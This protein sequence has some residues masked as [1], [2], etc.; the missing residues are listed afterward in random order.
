MAAETAIQ[1]GRIFRITFGE[2]LRT[3]RPSSSFVKNSVLLKCSKRVS[4][5]HFRPFIRVITGR[6]SARED[7]VERC[8]DRSSL[9]IRKDT[10]WLQN[11]LLIFHDSTLRH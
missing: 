5:K 9:N 3:E 6:V 1:Y 10:I 4:L 8:R 7:M 11:I 2:D